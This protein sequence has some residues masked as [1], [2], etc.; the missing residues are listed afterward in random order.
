[1]RTNV[2]EVENLIRNYSAGDGG[3][4]ARGAVPGG[5]RQRAGRAPHPAVQGTG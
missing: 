5:P 2:L 3:G 1:M 4:V